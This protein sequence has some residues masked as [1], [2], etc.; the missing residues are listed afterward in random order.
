[1][2]QADLILLLFLRLMIVASNSYQGILAKKN[3]EFG[4]KNNEET[5]IRHEAMMK[6]V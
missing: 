5:K 6:A 2:E 4:S 3:E 1:M